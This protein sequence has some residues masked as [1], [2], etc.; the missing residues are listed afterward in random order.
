[1]TN[2]MTGVKLTNRAGTLSVGDQD[3]VD[4][5]Q[6]CYYPTY[7]FLID[8]DGNIYLCPKIGNEEFLWKC[9]ARTIFDLWTGKILSKFRKICY[10]VSDAQVHA[11]VVTLMENYLKESCKK[12]ERYL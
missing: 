12:M 10:W 1:M 3:D 6:S 11:L 5:T 9:H 2:I 4:I 8:W 7:Q